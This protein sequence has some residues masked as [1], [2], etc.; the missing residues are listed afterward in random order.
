[1]KKRIILIIVLVIIVIISVSYFL[2]FSQNNNKDLSS[3]KRVCDYLK[4]I[5]PYNCA[6]NECRA[7]DKITFWDVTYRCPGPAQFPMGQSYLLNVYKNSGKI[8]VTGLTN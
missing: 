6:N 1:M 2:L 3:E 7:D 8:E 5:S 4:T